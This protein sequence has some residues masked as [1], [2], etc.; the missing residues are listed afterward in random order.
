M[1][2][3]K[4]TVPYETLKPSDN[5]CPRKSTKPFEA[6]KNYYT[7]RTTHNH[8]DCEKLLPKEKK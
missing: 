6:V 3:D 5:E 4:K 2:R 7:E 8:K 1:N